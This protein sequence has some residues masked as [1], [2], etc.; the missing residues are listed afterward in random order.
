M[1][2]TP[3]D[4][5]RWERAA[6]IFERALDAPRNAR[7]NLIETEA[8]GDADIIATVRGMLAADENTGDLIDDGVEQLASLAFGSEDGARSL[9]PGDR[10][11]DFE[12]ISEIGR[13]GMGVVYAARDRKLGRIAA[14]KLLPADSHLDSE[15]SERLIAEAQAASALDHPNVATIYQIGE[16]A[17]GRGFIAMARYEGETLRERLARGPINPREAFAIARQVASGLAAAHAAGLVHRDVKPENIFLTK[18]GLAKLLDFGIATLAGTA[19]EGQTTRGTI[20][21]MSPEQVNRQTP[22]TPADVWALG[23]VLCEMLAGRIPF[24]G[25]TAREILLQITDSAPV[26]LPAIVKQIPSAAGAVLAKSLEKDQRKRIH[27]AEE[28]LAQLERVERLWMRPRLIQAGIAAAVVLVFAGWYL[29]HSIAPAPVDRTT[30]SLAV[31][32]VTGDSLDAESTSLASALGDEIAARIAGL[33]RMRLVRLTRDSAYK[34]HIPALHLMSLSMDRGQF[35]PTITVSLERADSRKTIWSTTRPLDRSELRE[36]SRD[37][38][39]GTLSAIGKPLNERERATIGSSFPSNSMAYEEYLRGNQLMSQRTPAAVES[40]MV[41]FRRAGMLDSTFASA[42]ARQSYAYTL[43]VD[44]G[45]KPTAEFPGNALDQGLAL[46]DRATQL[47][48]TSADGWLARA[49]LLVQKDPARFSGS[50]EAFQHAIALDPYNAEAFHQYGQTLMSLGRYNEALA[51]YRRVLDLEPNRAM[52]LVPMAAI[53][54][55]LGRRLEALRYLDSAIAAFPNIPYVRA[56]RALLRVQLG[57]LAGARA[58]AEAGVA[59]PSTAPVPQLATLARVLWLQGDTLRALARLAE[60]ERALVNPAAPHPTDA[61]WLEVGEVTVGRIDKAKQLA[62][63]TR[64][65][66]ALMWFMFQAEE[67]GDLRKDAEV[68]ALLSGIDPRTPAR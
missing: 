5:E 9:S 16:T 62:R 2:R 31:L 47:D 46:A 66:G 49:Y 28:L 4:P 7:D 20:M 37:L 34:A 33:G 3:L 38:V 1:I 13:G 57:D 56:T 8:R 11:G 51:A 15:A 67:L 53:S 17:D 19:R 48:S 65:R 42:L 6:E 39:I 58:D 24:S 23:V 30:P 60:A 18:Q 64:P 36:I 59:V 55:R 12:I 29:I 50:I 63:T 21:Y 54:K 22:G 68:A 25:G 26:R 44:W 52:T 27:D 43:L 14:L 41:S 45:W 10:I 61:F 32:P 40:A 35:L